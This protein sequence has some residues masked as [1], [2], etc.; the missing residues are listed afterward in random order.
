MESKL[1]RRSFIKGAFA[2]SAITAGSVLVACDTQEPIVDE[3]EA[4][5]ITPISFDF[6]ADVVVVGAGFAGLATAITAYDEGA[7]VILIEKAPEAEAG[8]NSR[9]CAQAVWTPSEIEAAIQYFKEIT[10][11][12][13][14]QG[15]TDEMVEAY[16]KESSHN[17]DWINH[18][19]D[20]E[21][22]IADSIE[23][24]LAPSAQI[25]RS[26]TMGI[27]KS[28][29]GHAVIWNALMDT[30]KTRAIDIMFETPLTDLI[31]SQTGEVIGIT[32]GELKIGALKGVVLC[33]GGFENDIAMN[34]NYLRY[35]SLFWGTP[36]NTGD[37]HKICQKYDIDFWHMNSATPATRVGLDMPGLDA[38][39]ARNSLDFEF[40]ASLSFFW[41]DKYGKRF[42]DEK[43][44]YQ[45]GFG[46]DAIFYNDGQKMEWPRLP[47]W[48]VFDAASA[49]ELEKPGRSGWLEVV[50]GINVSAGLEKEI[51]AGVVFKGETPE[52]L[53]Q[54]AGLDVTSFVNQF[55]RYNA[56]AQAGEDTEFGRNPSKMAPLE[57]GPF[58]IAKVYPVMVNTNG[59]PRRNEKAEILKTD[60]TP[61]PRLYSSGEFGSI[62]A[63]YYQGA[64]NVAECFAFG[65]IAARNVVALD[66]WK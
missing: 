10:G 20:I 40:S 64:G 38:K 3:S 15:I 44:E 27:P 36:F 35:P 29:L 42:M 43:R 4:N 59:G 7:S 26:R 2:V 24:P 5:A 32:S 8:G 13:H 22:M 51:A 57:S 19:A 33:L 14:G 61:V 12:Y 46:R 50:A 65:R 53:A 6:E 23:Y 58:Y 30:I 18:T 48:Q 1:D 37:G 60:G 56:M 16:I 52:A 25:A 11:D 31:Y 17:V 9:V 49:A 54:A 66:S 45:H 41:T 21:M 34:A 39:Y 47:M 55:N 28:G 63:W 62:W